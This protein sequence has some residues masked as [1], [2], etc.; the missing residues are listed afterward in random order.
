MDQACKHGP[1][2]RSPAMDWF[3]KRSVDE[4]HG[5]R[6][7]FAILDLH[8][9]G[10]HTSCC[11]RAASCRR[12]EDRNDEKKN[13]RKEQ[14]HCT[15][16]QTYGYLGLPTTPPDLA[17]KLTLERLGRWA[18]ATCL[19]ES[20]LLDTGKSHHSYIDLGGDAIASNVHAH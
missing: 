8:L 16:V 12:R 2:C 1:T 9:C 13:K 5:I 3:R 4:M 11:H 14:T 18:K 7:S 6:E 19:M 10:S 15:Y 20:P 17:R